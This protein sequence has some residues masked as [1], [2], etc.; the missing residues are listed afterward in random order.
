MSPRTIR[1]VLLIHCSVYNFSKALDHS[2]KVAALALLVHQLIS[3]RIL[4]AVALAKQ[5]ED[6]RIQM[7]MQ[8]I[9]SMLRACSSGHA[10]LQFFRHQE[11]LNSEV[12]ILA[13]SL[14]YKSAADMN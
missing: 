3:A 13:S 4:Q 1:A 9:T 6:L 5:L 7:D 14:T 10:A 12:I 2:D 8:A 11:E